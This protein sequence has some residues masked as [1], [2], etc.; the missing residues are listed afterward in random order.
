M[1]S[2]KTFWQLLPAVTSFGSLYSCWLLWWL[3][4]A[5]NCFDIFSKL[6]EALRALLVLLI[7]K[8]ILSKSAQPGTSCF[9]KCFSFSLEHLARISGRWAIR[10]SK[11]KTPCK[12]LTQTFRSVLAGFVWQSARLHKEAP[13]E[14][15]LVCKMN[16][17]LLERRVALQKNFIEC[18]QSTPLHF[19][20]FISLIE[21]GAA[22]SF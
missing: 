8:G 22:P 16:F 3:L 4:Q 10:S 20:R 9:Y 14:E 5:A 18:V 11:S 21:W 6:L 7:V 1:T 15:R 19:W 2:L 12:W 13:D 17:C